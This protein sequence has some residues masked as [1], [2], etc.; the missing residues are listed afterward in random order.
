MPRYERRS[1]IQLEVRVDELAVNSRTSVIG[2]GR[3]PT[4]VRFA[5]R[6]MSGEALTFYIDIDLFGEEL[7]RAERLHRNGPVI[8]GITSQWF[9]Q[10]GAHWEQ[11]VLTM[12]LERFATPVK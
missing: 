5:V 12:A 7:N 8:V 10:N 11:E 2:Q 6:S 4:T 9:G 3:M 1:P